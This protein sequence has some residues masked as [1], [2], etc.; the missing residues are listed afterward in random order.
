[1]L[2]LLSLARQNISRHKNTT[3]AEDTNDFLGDPQLERFPARAHD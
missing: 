2:I 3:L 1:L